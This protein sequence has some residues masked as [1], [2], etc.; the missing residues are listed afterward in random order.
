VRPAAGQSLL[1]LGE[2]ADDVPAPG[3]ELPGLTGIVPVKDEEQNV[4]ACIRSFAEI[5]D[6]IIVVDSG[7]KD[8]TVELARHFTDRI[9]VRPWVDYRTFLKFAMPR[10]RY[11]W[12]LIVDADERLTPSLRQQ[13]RERVDAEGAGAVGFRMKRSSHFMGRRIR[14]SGWQ[15]DFVYRFFKK[16]KGGPR[17]R[18]AHPGI[19]IDGTIEALDGL[20]LHFPYPTLEDYLAKFNRYTSG[21]A[22]DRLKRGKRVTRV[23]RFL[24]PPARF[25]RTYVL[26]LGFLDGYPGFV[27]SALGAFYVFMR[28]T[29]MWQYQNAERL[30]AETQRLAVLDGRGGKAAPLRPPTH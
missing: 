16:G 28:Y 26:R 2:T 4:E 20:L 9:Y 15:N 23:D 17:E 30:A 6:E 13:I 29:K 22:R 1:P 27:L 5:C 18:E 3:S 14:Y 25:L 19:V 24:S 8:R 21:A 12:L 10:A 7:S 11:R